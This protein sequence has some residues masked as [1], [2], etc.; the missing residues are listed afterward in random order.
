MEL[1]APAESPMEKRLRWLLMSNGLPRP[2]VQAD[3]H[4]DAGHLSAG[5]TFST[6]LRVSWSSLTEATTGSG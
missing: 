2:E 5:P 4:D 6:A 3:L 1:A